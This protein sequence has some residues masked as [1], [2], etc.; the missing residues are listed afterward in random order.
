MTRPAGGGPGRPGP[1][2]PAVPDGLVRV[3]TLTGREYFVQIGRPA[4]EK[5]LRLTHAE[6]A[7]LHAR[8]GEALGA[9]VAA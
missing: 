7:Q 6:A 2:T 1:A 3:T 4:R 8:L 5:R 9:D